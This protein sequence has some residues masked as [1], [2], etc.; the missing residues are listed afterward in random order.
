[1]LLLL[2]LVVLSCTSGTRLDAGSVAP[3]EGPSQTALAE[4][5]R[6][7]LR[8]VFYKGNRAPPPPSQRELRLLDRNLA[9]AP[10]VEVEELFDLFG[11]DRELLAYATRDSDG[12][13]VLDY[14]ISEYHGKF[15][16]GDIDLDGDGVRNVYDIDPYD[17]AVG[18]SDSDGDGVPDRPG[19]F[20]DR[21]GDGI[22]DHLD[23]SRRKPEPLPSM[24]TALFRDFDVI[25]VERSARFTPELVQAA[26]DAL[27]HV[28]REPLPTLR[29]IAVEDQLL[30]DSDL[31]DNGFMLGQTQTLTVYSKSLE[32]AP[33]L[34]LFGLLVHEVDHAWQLAQDFDAKDLLGE[35]KKM[36]FPVGEFTTSLRRYG[37]DVDPQTNGDGYHHVLYWPQFYATSPRYLYQGEAPSAWGEWFE[38]QQER[39][40][41]GFLRA[42]PLTSRGLVGP[43][44]MTSPW[45]WHADYLMAS[46]YHRVDRRLAEHASAPLLRARM[47]E[48]VQGQWSRFDY[49][50]ISGTKVER[51][52]AIDFELGEA[53]LDALIER[54]VIPLADLPLLS[55]ALRL[56]VESVGVDAL[57]AEWD[58]LRGELEAPLG[59]NSSLAE[60]FSKPGHT[61]A[62]HAH[63]HHALAESGA[64]PATVDEAEALADELPAGPGEAEAL[65]S[66]KLDDAGAP[67]EP[68][69]VGALRPVGELARD[70]DPTGAPLS[71]TGAPVGDG[72]AAPPAGSMRGAAA[73]LMRLAR[74]RTPTV[75]ADPGEPSVALR[76]FEELRREPQPPE[77]ELSS[78][79][80]PDA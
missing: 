71:P 9:G 28:F 21:D 78:P 74:A 33:A 48:A 3:G 80:Q 67:T 58:K 53:E 65:A 52:L 18:G 47:L 24:Q 75:T 50:N 61:L 26:D 29:T 22:P 35:N 70:L 46:I 2:V 13:G 72:S 66:E 41:E 77:P 19:S 38:D 55:R 37:W 11:N 56:E 23:W 20:A 30:L 4:A 62:G 10:P 44:A 1:M 42:S 17:P 16:E 68:V 73:Q 76:A 15:F 57:V 63:G 8:Y 54:Y 39:H 49:R 69:P 5:Q 60:L 64:D 79:D 32:G 27:R 25:L 36:H 12:D 14:R 34:V 45:E 51:E 31:G 6:E 43:Y 59:A 40:G 7:S